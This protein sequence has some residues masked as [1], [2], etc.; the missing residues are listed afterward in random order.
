MDNQSLTKMVYCDY[1][2]QTW[3]IE[4][5]LSLAHVCFHGIESDIDNTPG[6]KTRISAISL[7]CQFNGTALMKNWKEGKN[8]NYNVTKMSKLPKN[9]NITTSKNE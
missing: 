5:Y 9:Q 2:R 3:L 8:H 1:L 6:N 7:K 4:T